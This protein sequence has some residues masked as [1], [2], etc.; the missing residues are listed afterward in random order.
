MPLLLTVKDVAGALGLST[1]R[2]YKLCV[3]G[4]LPQVRLFGD[5]IRVEIAIP[6]RVRNPRPGA[7]RSSPIPWRAAR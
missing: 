3:S 2:V 1:A 5:V 4:E 6:R 7:T